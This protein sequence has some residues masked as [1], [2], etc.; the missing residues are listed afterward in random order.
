MNIEI[1]LRALEEKLDPLERVIRLFT[2]SLGE[3]TLRKSND[4]RGFRYEAP[5]VQ[6]FCLL[7]AVRAL[8]ALNAAIELARKGYTQEIAVLMRTLIECTTHIEFVL[9]IDYEEEHRAVVR[10]YI[11]DF[12][13]DERRSPIAEIRRAQIQQGKVHATLGKTLDR[14][15]EE[16]GETESRTPAAQL[17]SNSYRIFSN[18]VHAKYPECMD[19]YGGRP[20]QFH[21]RGMNG[22][23]K[24]GENLEI[25]Q[26][27]AGTLT[28][29]FVRMIQGLNLLRFV[30]ADPVVGIWYKS[31]FEK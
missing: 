19:L 30:D 27:F 20:G 7:K 31:I 1:A 11:G 25:L 24:E 8:S 6:H 3:P 14:I 5:G 10:K 18:Y 22:T 26:T 28:N 4:E 15:A 12:F 17:Y 29:C 13:A 2:A 23:P 9:E 21:T 16:L